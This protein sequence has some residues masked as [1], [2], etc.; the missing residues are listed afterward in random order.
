MTHP[1][2]YDQD[3]DRAKRLEV[4]HQQ[5]IAAHSD[6]AASP[7][8]S[9]SD[10]DLISAEYILR[11][12]EQMRRAPVPSATGETRE[13]PLVSN[14]ETGVEGFEVSASDGEAVDWL[15]EGLALE[16]DS[17]SPRTLGRFQIE[18]LLGRGGFGLVFLAYDPRL[19]RQV[20]L[21]IPGLDILASGQASRRFLREAKAAAMLSHPG[22][23]TVY[24]AGFVGPAAYLAS[25]YVPGPN[26]SQWLARQP[27][28]PSPNEAALAVASLASAVQHAHSRS[29]IHRDLK[30]G[31]IQVQEQR[32]SATTLARRLKITDFG[33]ARITSSV[34]QVT[35]SGVVLGTPAYMAPEMARGEAARSGPAVDIYSLGAIL[36]ELLTGAPPHAKSSLVATLRAVEL[37]E[38]VA[39]RR[40]KPAIP[41]DLEA[42][43]LRALDKSPAQRYASAFDLQDDLERFLDGRAIQ[44]RRVSTLGRVVRWSTRNPAVAGMMVGAVAMMIT[45]IAALTSM[46]I[47]AERDRQVIM[48]ERE[49]VVR[50]LGFAEQAVD[51]LLTE[52]QQELAEFPAMDQIRSRLLERA[53]RVQQHIV[54]EQDNHPGSRLQLVRALRRVGQIQHVLGNNVESETSLVRSVSL[55]R[56]I[57]NDVVHLDQEIVTEYLTAIQ[58]LSSTLRSMGRDDEAIAII[59]DAVAECDEFLSDLPFELDLWSAIWGVRQEFGELTAKA[60]PAEAVSWFQELADQLAMLLSLHTNLDEDGVD[61]MRMQLASTHNSLG[62]ALRANGQPEQALSAYADS[63]GT[64]RDLLNRGKLTHLQ[65]SNMSAT[66]INLGNFQF[67]RGQYDAAGANYVEAAEILQTLTYE[68]PHRPRHKLSLGAALLGQ[69]LVAYR[70]GTLEETLSYLHSALS[71]FEQGLVQHLEFAHIWQD[72]IARVNVNRVNALTAQMR[73]DEALEAS[74]A[75]VAHRRQRCEAESGDLNRNSELAVALSN[76]GSTYAM[77]EREQD[78]LDCWYEA[79]NYHRIAVEG[80]PRNSQ[81]SSRFMFDLRQLVRRELARQNY[82]AAALGL[83]QWHHVPKTTAEYAM[84]FARFASSLVRA[85]LVELDLVAIELAPLE[86]QLRLTFLVDAAFEHLEWATAQAA[87]DRSSL[88]IDHQDWQPLIGDARWDLLVLDHGS[89]H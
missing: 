17:T 78:A 74:A 64:S 15:R 35:V 26:L 71:V 43:C 69:G 62:I 66:L 57:G 2:E 59:L 21:K 84:D 28:P 4:I 48:S 68:N 10:P 56:E 33:L 9:T 79:L 80:Q 37:E 34:E 5:L 65:K 13:T 24:E 88:D 20:A 82:E 19:E 70:H 1:N 45:A 49:R 67:S 46:L 60:S 42:I 50:S 39:P 89:N 30:P 61:R 83:M 7:A 22:I 18:R 23:V 81:F 8:P 76:Q 6:D 11:M 40:I 47:R 27:V 52:V 54:A 51:Q 3:D 25:E 14:V 77:M 53:L 16:G 36:Y 38:P 86:V 41:R 31:N 87:F 72:E 73:F 29:V 44:A 55:V 12:M 32:D 63:L 75:V 85:E 58:A